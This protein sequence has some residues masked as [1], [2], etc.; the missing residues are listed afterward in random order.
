MLA[1]TVFQIIEPEDVGDLRADALD[2]TDYNRTQNPARLGKKRTRSM[3]TSPMTNRT[4]T[5]TV[6]P[7]AD[8]GTVMSAEDTLDA[9]RRLT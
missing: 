8:T 1:R 3:L 2:D 7:I 6:F 9:T 4:T 5:D